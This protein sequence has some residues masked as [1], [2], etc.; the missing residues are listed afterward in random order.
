MDIKV[1]LSKVKSQK[2]NRQK[3]KEIKV[4][5]QINQ[6]NKSQMAK[7]KLVKSLLLLRV[8]REVIET[9]QYEDITPPRCASCNC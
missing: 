5:W 1:K 9:H 8:F 3:V 4:K 6:R 7:K 2:S